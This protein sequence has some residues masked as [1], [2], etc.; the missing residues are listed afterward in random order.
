MI[1]KD[2][3]KKLLSVKKSCAS[4]D[5]GEGQCLLEQN[6]NFPLFKKYI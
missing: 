4:Q 1:Q 5:V 6:N 3:E 2:G